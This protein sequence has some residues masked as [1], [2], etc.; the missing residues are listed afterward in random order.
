MFTCNILNG[1]WEIAQNG[2]SISVHIGLLCMARPVKGP[3]VAV[4]LDLK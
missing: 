4:Y 1:R 3:A 2:S